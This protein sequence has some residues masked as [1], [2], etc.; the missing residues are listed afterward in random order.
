ME[1]YHTII[2]RLTPTD[3]KNTAE[4]NCCPRHSMQC[5]H[6][7]LYLYHMKSFDLDS[8]FIHEKPY[9]HKH[10]ILILSIVL[11]V[12]TKINLVNY[13]CNAKSSKLDTTVRLP[14]PNFLPVY[15]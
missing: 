12:L 4:I 11:M 3:R 10:K 1:Q 7:I 13:F 5:L 2:P 15:V 14:K 6:E 8:K 9:I